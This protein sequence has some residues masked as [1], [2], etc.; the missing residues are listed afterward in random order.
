MT[1]ET[2]AAEFGNRPATTGSRVH[3]S[4]SPTGY[5]S[6]G[7]SP[8]EPA[9][10]SPV[11]DHRSSIPMRCLVA[12]QCRAGRIHPQR[13]VISTLRAGHRR[14]RAARAGAD[15]RRTRFSGHRTRPGAQCEECAAVFVGHRPRQGAGHP[16][17]RGAHDHQFHRPGSE[18]RLN[19]GNLDHENQYTNAGSAPQDECLLA[20]REL[21]VGWPN[22]SLRQSAAEAAADARRCEAHVAGTVGASHVYQLLT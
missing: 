1:L 16:H 14:E 13:G 9:C 4:E 10:A 8:A 18:S 15:L 20:R 6:A 11:T 12:I 3:W 22:L 2:V 17:R 21:S 19:S 7:C 5:S